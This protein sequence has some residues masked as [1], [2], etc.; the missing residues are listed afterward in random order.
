MEQ[1]VNE[2]GDLWRGSIGIFRGGERRIANPPQVGSLPTT[3]PS[4]ILVKAIQTAIQAASFVL[5]LKWLIRAN[6]DISRGL[7]HRIPNLQEADV[8]Q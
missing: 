4:L 1:I 3:E 2:V 8:V 5:I 7:G 6:R